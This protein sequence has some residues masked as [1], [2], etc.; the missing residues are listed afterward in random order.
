MGFDLS[1]PKL[2][3]LIVDDNPDDRFAYRR[4]LGKAELLRFEISEAVD[5]ES[6]LAAVEAGE[7]QFVLLDLHL[8]DT[9]GLELLSQLRLRYPRLPIVMLTGLDD[10]NTSVAALKAGAD[11]YQIK[12]K[13][14]TD[15]L[16]R[17]IR[18]ALEK[19][20]LETQLAIERERLELFYRLV[21]QSGDIM[22]VVE[23]PQ[24]RLIELN[25]AAVRMLG[26]SRLELL[27]AQ[28][29][30]TRLFPK[31]G[32]RWEALTNEQPELRYACEAIC[33]DGSVLPIESSVRRVVI[34]EHRYF[35]LSLRDATER[36]EMESQ[37]RRLVLLDA[38]TGV[39]NR[40][41]FDERFEQEFLRAAR[42]HGALGLLMIDIDQ[43]KNYND[44]YGH[45]AGDKCLRQIAQALVATLKRPSDFVAR[46]GGEEFAV[47]LPDADMPGTLAAAELLLARVRE[48]ALPHAALS[49]GGTVSVSIGAALAKPPVRGEMATFLALADQRLYKAKHSGRNRAVGAD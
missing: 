8:P 17:A 32:Q 16:L 18:S 23:M 36:R 34:H 25:E 13:L 2:R 37:L 49:L 1:L 46:Y 11:D 6:A 7:P 42:G 5:A 12:G 28:F 4:M 31:L 14:G 40:R 29:D 43:F 9:T 48:L 45:Q 21:E 26:Y 15:S 20:A 24:R 19:R 35:V 41:A 22:M 30:L 10:V 3:L 27:D 44:H 38:L 33:K 47:L 39:H